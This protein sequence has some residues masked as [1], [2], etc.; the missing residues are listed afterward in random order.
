MQL[1][2]MLDIFSALRS[3][4]L[5]ALTSANNCYPS[6]ISFRLADSTPYS[7]SS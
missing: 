5:I 2:T 6:G 7:I 4:L 3:A 1:V